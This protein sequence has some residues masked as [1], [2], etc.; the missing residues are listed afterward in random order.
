MLQPT[1]NTLPTDVS[2]V[3]RL[4]ILALLP[5]IAVFI[6]QTGWGGLLNLCIASGS[7]LAF[8]YFALKLRNT[9][10]AVVLKDNSAL[11]TG[12]L[13]AL[14]LPP[15]LPWWITV[16]AVGFAILLAKHCYGGLG[17]N[18]F[19]PAMAGYAVI[20]ISFPR[21][22]SLWP[23]MPEAFTTSLPDT[24]RIS[25][26]G[27]LSQMPNWDALTGATALD[28]IR[29]L[30]LQETATTAIKQKTHGLVG[31]VHSEWI[32]FAYLAGGIALLLTRV[33]SWHIPAGVLGALF[34]CSLTETLVSGESA[35]DTGFHIF[36]GATML[37][38]FFI[39]TDP[40]SAATSNRGRLFYGAGIGILIFTIRTWGSYPD[41]I[42]FAILLMNCLVPMIDRLDPVLGR[43]KL[44]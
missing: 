27:G 19:N 25:F 33:I 11:V 37:C 5:G 2:H 38:A 40:V 34:V 1:N 13:V 12:L 39:A 23:A 30:S 18:I 15:L 6:Y 7:A 41:S 32:N 24:L 36:S 42:A 3:M 17:R 43:R 29:D 20:L 4:V 35:M 26:G 21:E 10:P 8:E 9:N 31:A 16:L 44:Q 22:L 14:C 28:M